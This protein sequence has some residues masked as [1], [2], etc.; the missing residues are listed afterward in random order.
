MCSLRGVGLLV[1]VDSDV[2]LEGLVETDQDLPCRVRPYSGREYNT[3]G[4]AHQ[5]NHVAGKRLLV[6][7]KTLP[8]FRAEGLWIVSEPPL[9]CNDLSYHLVMKW[10]V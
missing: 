6:N 10:G 9:T 2:A 1:E 8:I 7:V 4:T 5:R 3:Y